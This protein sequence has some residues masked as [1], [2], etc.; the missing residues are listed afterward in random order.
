ME[1]TAEQIAGYLGGEIDGNA[2][3]RVSTFSKIEDPDTGLYYQ[4]PVYV[5]DILKER[6]PA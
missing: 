3:E 5:F 2:G 6:G 1:F 4:S